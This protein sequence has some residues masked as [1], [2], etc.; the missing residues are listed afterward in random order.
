MVKLVH[1][2]VEGAH[3]SIRRARQKGMD[4]IKKAFKGASEDDRKRAEKEVRAQKSWGSNGA[5]PGCCHGSQSGTRA[6]VGC[7][8][9]RWALRPR[10]RLCK[11]PSHAAHSTPTKKTARWQVQK[12]H[13]R[14]LAET[15][16]LKKAKDSELREH[17]D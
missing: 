17:R 11:A 3:Q 12:L 10:A 14:F 6:G 7:A 15:E 2:E 13:D 8:H 4:A 9:L 1:M 5:Q 16:R